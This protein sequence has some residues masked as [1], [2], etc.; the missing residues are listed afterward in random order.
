MYQHPPHGVVCVGYPV[1]LW[2]PGHTTW[3]LELSLPVLRG[4]NISWF[5]SHS[6]SFKLFKLKENQAQRSALKLQDC[7][8][9]I[10]TF[11][12]AK[13]VVFPR[14]PPFFPEL[15]LNYLRVP[16][17]SWLALQ[18]ALSAHTR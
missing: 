3:N 16:W 4:R 18:P 2:I 17:L 15:A 13:S 7:Q 12:H 11:L 5:V 14:L 9:S 1:Y 8:Q 10:A 6:S